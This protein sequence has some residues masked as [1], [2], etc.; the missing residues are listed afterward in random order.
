MKTLVLAIG[1]LLALGGA[2]AVI[3]P[4]SSVIISSGPDATSDFP[5]PVLDD[6][7]KERSK[8]LG[9]IAIILGAGICVAGF[10]ATDFKALPPHDNA[11]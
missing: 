9:Y 3:T 6:V 4:K 10:L 1:C 7:S 8:K 2:I 11:A 5:K